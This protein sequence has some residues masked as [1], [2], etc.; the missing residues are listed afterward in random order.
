MSG[1]TPGWPSS[2]TGQRPATYDGA[3]HATERR[4]RD[5]G[6]ELRALATALG[7]EP[8]LCSVWPAAF[9]D[10]DGADD[11]EVVESWCAPC[12][13]TRECAAYGEAIKAEVGV[14]GGR[15]RKAKPARRH[16]KEAS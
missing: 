4:A 14:W 9:T 15:R 13:A 2:W 3:G 8:P 10:T 12:P 5:A 16:N 11:V 6:V 7:G 1:R